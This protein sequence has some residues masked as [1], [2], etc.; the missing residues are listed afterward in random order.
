LDPFWKIWDPVPNPLGK[1]P[2]IAGFI[3]TFIFQLGAERIWKGA[4]EIWG[5]S[6]G[7]LEVIWGGSGG[8]LERIWKG[9]GED[10][11]R[12]W[13]GSGKEQGRI[14]RLGVVCV[15]LLERIWK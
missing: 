7:D 10:L 2:K 14:P 8:D 13:I 9:A 12:S 11:E 6:G 4:G 5:G 3:W 15:G 1:Y